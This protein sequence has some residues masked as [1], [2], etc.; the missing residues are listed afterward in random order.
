[1][2]IIKETVCKLCEGGSQVLLI[3]MFPRDPT[4]CF[5]KV[6]TQ[7][8]FNNWLDLKAYIQLLS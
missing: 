3:F 2:C 1:M 8:V 4:K 5:Q 7:S 6:G